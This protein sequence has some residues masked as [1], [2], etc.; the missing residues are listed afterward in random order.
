MKKIALI[1]LFLVAFN[2]FGKNLDANKVI[3]AVVME[4][5]GEPYKA[6]VGI[7]AV[8]RRR[9]S[10]HGVYGANA[11]RVEAQSVYNKVAKAW[12]ESATSDPTGGCDLFGGVIDD[13]YFQ[14]ELGL[15]PVLT[16]GNTRFYK[17][18]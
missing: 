7:C 1:S 10:L 5:S 2:C 6:Q 13:H 15:K 3:H 8:I 11:H 4:A 18:K 14:G 17:S 9:G 12:K 16:I